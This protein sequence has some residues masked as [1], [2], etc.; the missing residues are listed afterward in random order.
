[1]STISQIERSELFELLPL[2]AAASAS[3]IVLQ[4]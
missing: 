4:R 1:M 3:A 2:Q